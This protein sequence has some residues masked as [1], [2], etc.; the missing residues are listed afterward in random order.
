MMAGVEERSDPVPSPG[1]AS[2]PTAAGEAGAT[3]GE[4]ATVPPVRLGPMTAADVL[5]A[6]FAVIEARPRRILAM[7]AAVV[8]PTRL[9]VALAQSRLVGDLDHID[10]LGD[11]ALTGGQAGAAA[12]DRYLVVALD[13]LLGGLALVVLAAAIGH[14]VGQWI[15]GRDAPAGEML[16]V[17]AR[18]WP[19]LVGSFLLVRAAE[20]AGAL[21]LYVGLLLVVPLLVAVAPVVGMEGGGPVEVVRRSVRLVR[22]RHLPVMGLAILMGVVAEV[23]VAALSAVPLGMAA[24]IG[25]DRGWLLAALGSTAAEVVT[26]PFVAAAT[27]WL[28]VDLRVRTEGFDIELAATRLLDRAGDGRAGAAGGQVG[29]SPPASGAA[30]VAGP[31]GLPVVAPD[32]ALLDVERAGVG[33]RVAA[34][35][36]DAAVLGAVLLVAAAPVVGVVDGGGR[37]GIVAAVGVGLAAALAWAC[38]FESLGGGRTPGKAVVGLRVLSA[39]G[40]P[41]RGRQALRRAAGGV[42]DLLLV[43]VGI[44][45]VVAVLSSPRRQRLGDVAAGT[46][47]VRERVAGAALRS[48]RFQPPSGWERYT[49]SIDV[50][51]LGDEAYALV[52]DLLLR[53]PSLTPAALD[54]LAVRIANPV[55][56]RL[57]HTPPPNVH[58]HAFLLCV[59]ARWQ[60]L[61]GGG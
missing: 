59:A 33:S 26:V 18:W 24:W 9:V 6:G 23:L 12:G 34:A 8:V 28:Y 46:V 31:G 11:P 30:A 48:P 40:T 60:L 36:L 52:R 37:A 35:S 39:D 20:L 54:H 10:L 19:S 61:H 42:L 56:V 16:G 44:V 58:P 3:G 5:D 32:G 29:G 7:A 49:A 50:S 27:V 53:A 22:P 25:L 14:L 2:G 57:G 15:M 21:A 13:L 55:A 41:E 1:S 43:P 51:R 4:G 17:V 38:A 47:V 45:A